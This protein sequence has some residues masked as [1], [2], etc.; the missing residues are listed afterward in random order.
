MFWKPYMPSKELPWNLKRV[1]HLHR[2]AGFAAD[3][4]SLQRDLEEGPDAAIGRLLEGNCGTTS[5]EFETLSPTIAES[6]IASTNPR[7]LQAW[8]IYRMLK[9]S[10]P[11]GERL[12]LMWHNH[13]ATSNRKVKS[14]RLMHEQNQIMRGN[15]RGKFCDLLSAVVKHPAMLIWLDGDSNRK[16]RCNENLA[17]ELLELFTLGVGNYT[18]RDVKNSAKALTGWTVSEDRFVFREKRHDDS[19]LRVLGK[20]Q[21]F[22]GD[23]LLDLLLKQPATAMRVAWRLCKAFM[24]EPFASN[25]RAAVA[26]LAKGLM[27]NGLSI[28]WVLRTI[29][30]SEAFFRDANI[31]S[32]VLGPTEFLVGTIRALEQTAAPPSTMLL[33]DWLTRMGLDLFYPPN[34]G[35]WSEGKS[36]LGSRH[37]IAR[38]NFAFSLVTGDLWN[39]RQASDLDELF[40]QHSSGD[41]KSTTERLCQLLHGEVSQGVVEQILSKANNTGAATAS[42]LSSPQ[43]QLG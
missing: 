27:S 23:Q 24:A 35:G 7:R 22:D 2:R 36:W 29:L 34:V 15:A 4:S 13:F 40:D 18:E 30:R 25:E 37:I 19:H 1:V 8:W 6:A 41:L 16:G 43:N 5:S 26:E 42:L 10:D 32:K 39:P 9:T 38:S 28:D 11:L 20:A 21:P 17:R 31:R 14:L 33:A 12:T 3:W